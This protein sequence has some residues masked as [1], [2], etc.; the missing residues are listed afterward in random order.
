MP[1]LTLISKVEL[2]D[3]GVVLDC[4]LNGQGR[5]CSLIQLSDDS[6]IVRLDSDQRPIPSDWMSH[7]RHIRWL[8]DN[9][10]VVWPIA[11]FSSSLSYIGVMSASG[12]SAI[13]S[14][15]PLNVFADRNLI[16]AT[17]SEEFTRIDVP[18]DQ[19]SDLISVFMSCCR[20][21]GHAA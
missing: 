17:F 20:F 4:D 6:S 21:R 5:L 2:G 10:V 8:G 19:Q 11:P 16:A 18:K 15:F 14:A 1:S 12:A 9:E 7:V 3:E 13:E